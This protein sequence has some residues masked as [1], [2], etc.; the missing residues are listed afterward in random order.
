MA[1]YEMK[2]MTGSLFKNEN[3]KSGKSP[4]FNGRIKIEGKEYWLNGF[5]NEARS[6]GKKYIG[7]TVTPV[8]DNGRSQ[9]RSSNNSRSDDDGAWGL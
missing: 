2:D 9:Q 3:P 5:N 7:L 1:E 6:S 4:P 8:E